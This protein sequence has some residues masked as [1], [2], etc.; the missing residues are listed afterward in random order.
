MM[1]GTAT[2]VRTFGSVAMLEPAAGLNMAVDSLPACAAE[3][4]PQAAVG[5][6][7]L[8]TQLSD[9]SLERLLLMKKLSR[10]ELKPQQ[11]PHQ[12]HSRHWRL[13]PL[14]HPP[15]YF[16]WGGAWGEHNIQRFSLFDEISCHMNPNWVL[17]AISMCH[18]FMHS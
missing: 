17:Q 18:V 16:F 10:Y 1:N 15:F 11:H 7:S 13:C 12:R 3:L 14:L 8:Q 5:W 9:N 4:S 2:P 6:Q